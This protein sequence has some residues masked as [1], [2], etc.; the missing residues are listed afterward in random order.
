MPANW[1][2]AGIEALFAGVARFYSRD[3]YPFMIKF[4]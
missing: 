1:V 3:F 4:C 2:V